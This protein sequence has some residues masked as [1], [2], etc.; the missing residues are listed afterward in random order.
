MLDL[1]DIPSKDLFIRVIFALSEFHNLRITVFARPFNRNES[2]TRQTVKML[3]SPLF[4]V[5]YNTGRTE[6]THNLC[7]IVI[8]MKICTSLLY[9]KISRNTSLSSSLEL[10]SDS[11]S[12]NDLWIK[13]IQ[14][15]NFVAARIKLY[16]IW[17]L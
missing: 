3:K 11:K 16:F 14:Y 9:F 6:K 10:L 13:L 7:C 2:T 8:D 12:M 15:E 5:Q 4:E 17:L 1:H